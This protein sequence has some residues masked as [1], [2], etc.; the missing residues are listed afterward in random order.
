MLLEGEV[1]SMG[2]AV[3]QRH[4]ELPTTAPRAAGCPVIGV[5]VGDWIVGKPTLSQHGLLDVVGWDPGFAV[6]R[7]GPGVTGGKDVEALVPSE[8]EP[9]RYALAGLGLV[10]GRQVVHRLVEA[11]EGVDGYWLPT[12]LK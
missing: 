2:G 7:F 3:L 11:A 8:S 12:R 10:E 9:N 5:T 1:R 4:H 6:D